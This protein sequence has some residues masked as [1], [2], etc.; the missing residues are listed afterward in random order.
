MKTI[1]M[2]L[3][4]FLVAVVLHQGQAHKEEEDLPVKYSDCKVSCFF[5][6][7]DGDSFFHCVVGDDLDSHDEE[8]CTG[9]SQDLK[10]GCKSCIDFFDSY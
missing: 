10:E 9:V 7:G 2:M 6:E 4:L 8:F 5:D 1:S 3:G